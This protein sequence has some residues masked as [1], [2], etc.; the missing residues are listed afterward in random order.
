MP[1]LHGEDYYTWKGRY[2]V[3]AMV[4]CDHLKKIRLIYSGWPGSAHDERVL[5]NSKLYQQIEVM[6]DSKQYILADSAYTPHCRII[7]PFKKY[8]RELSHQQE[9]FNLKISQAQ[10][11]IELFIRMLK[12]RFQCLK[13]LR[14]SASCRKNAKRVVDQIDCC[15]IV[16]NICI[17]MSNDPV[18]EDW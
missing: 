3:N 11:C 15:A 16:H 7:P 17:E 6:A 8:S 9:R 4:I 14:V 18:E 12:A 13:E 10:I 2:A 5:T 1:S